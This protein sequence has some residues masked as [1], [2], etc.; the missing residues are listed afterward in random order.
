M[1]YEII[2]NFL[3]K[4]SFLNIKNTLMSNNFPYYYNKE[5]S[6]LGTKEGI[7]FTHM[8]FSE[9]SDKS[10]HY[11]LITPI[12][13]KLKAKSLIRIKANAYIPTNKIIEH[14]S[15]IDYNFKHSGFLYYVNTNDGFTRLGK[16]IKI[17]SIENRGLIFEP[18]LEHNSSTCTNLEGRININFNYF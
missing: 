17:K 16:N 2:D 13:K 4:E 8:F 5:I 10:I 15:H 18:Y 9:S 11:S 1:K 6:K 12:I 3:D 14:G 7:Y